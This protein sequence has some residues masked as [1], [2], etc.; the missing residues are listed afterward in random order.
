MSHRIKTRP[1]SVLAHAVEE[2]ECRL[3]RSSVT[4]TEPNGLPATANVIDLSSPAVVNA[5]MPDG[6]VEY[7][8]FTLSQRSGVF[9][10]IDSA[11]TGLSSSLDTII[12]LFDGAGV[13]Q[14][15]TNDDGRDFETFA[16]NDTIATPLAFGDSS[17]YDDLAAGTYMLKVASYAGVSGNYQLKISAD[18]SF[19]STVPTYSSK[20]GAADTLY[21]DF[22]GHAASDVWGTYSVPAYDLNGNASEWTPAEKLAIKN[23][24]SVVADDFA[25]FDINVTTSS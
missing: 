20:P 1:R 19:S 24:W 3:L 23:I 21:L 16:L 22:D 15:D 11:E 17:L 10:D 9:F 12:T 6:D 8:K 18:S 13:N 7:F 5:S 25:P 2:L 14:I 4:E